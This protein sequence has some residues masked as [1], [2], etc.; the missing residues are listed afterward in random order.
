MAVY[1]FYGDEDYN[2]DL[3]IEDMKSK[4]NPDFLAMSF[5]VYDN[6]EYADLI[7]TLRTPPMMFGDMLV[8]VNADKYFSS[9]KNYFEDNELADIEDALNN[10]PES[11]NVVFVV[12]LPREENKK[13]DTRR[14]LYKIV[15]KFTRVSNF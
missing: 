15:S 4:L 10:N 8:I 11:L 12:K 1:F 3:A 9:Q 6:P 5:Q 2:I 7:Q 14:K 13:I